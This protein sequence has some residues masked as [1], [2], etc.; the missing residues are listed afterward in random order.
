MIRLA[1]LLLALL[2]A[3][4]ACGGGDPGSESA[5]ETSGSASFPVTVTGSRAVPQ[6]GHDPG[7][8][9]RISGC[10]GHVYSASRTVAPSGADC[11]VCV[12]PR[13]SCG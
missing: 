7:P 4:T 1:A 8:G 12:G 3:V 13:T 11:T 10:I 9:R 2:L 5:A 6:I